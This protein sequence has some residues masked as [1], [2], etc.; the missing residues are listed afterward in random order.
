[1]ESKR[2]RFIR[3]A[4]ARTNK[5]LK[6]VELLGN[7]SNTSSY[8]YTEDDINLIYNRI[9]EELNKTR[10][11]FG[12]NIKRTNEVFTLENSSKPVS[13]AEICNKVKMNMTEE[14][15]WL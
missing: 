12:F 4:E 8:E 1:M 9:L 13:I 6:M 10:G 14:K 15:E 3:L 2:E 11:R 5:I 7:L